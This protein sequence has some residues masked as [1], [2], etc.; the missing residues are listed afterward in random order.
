MANDKIKSPMKNN[1]IKQ[2][3]FFMASRNIQD[4]GESDSDKKNNGELQQRIKQDKMALKRK[5]SE[6]SDQVVR[7]LAKCKNLLE[8][9]VQTKAELK[10]I[11]KATEKLQNQSLNL[12]KQLAK[13]IET[14]HE[15]AQERE[16]K[17]VSDGVTSEQLKTALNDVDSHR[18]KSDSLAALVS[19]LLKSNDEIES[20]VEQAKIRADEAEVHCQQLDQCLDLQA[21]R[22]DEQR[23]QILSLSEAIDRSTK[24]VTEELSSIERIKADFD[25]QVDA[26]V[27]ERNARDKM[28]Q[29]LDRQNK[30]FINAIK[31]LEQKVKLNTAAIEESKLSV[32]SAQQEI[33]R[34]FESCKEQ[35]DQIEGW[36]DDIKAS[37]SQ[38]EKIL[39]QAETIRQATGTVVE[40]CETLNNELRDELSERS[41]H[42]KNK[43]NQL[44]S[45]VTDLMDNCS[46]Q[47]SKVETFSKL[48]DEQLHKGEEYVSRIEQARDESN[49]DIAGYI[50][51]F[52]ATQTLCD[53]MREQITAEIKAGESNRVEISK[54]KDE[55]AVSLNEIKEALLS[56]SVE[57]E[58]IN[59]LLVEL[60]Q[61]RDFVREEINRIKNEIKKRSKKTETIINSQAEKNNQLIEQFEELK[62][63]RTLSENQ[64][65]DVLHLLSEVEKLRADNK[66]AQNEINDC[67][68]Q[69]QGLL[70]AEE[71][72]QQQ[73][74]EQQKIVQ[75]M[76]AE[77]NEKLQL[78]N[79]VG[80]DS[81]RMQKLF[82]NSLNEWR[83]VSGKI[84]SIVDEGRKQNQLFRQDAEKI[85][86]EVIGHKDH[87]S[88]MNKTTKRAIKIIE[89]ARSQ[90]K[91]VSDESKRSLEK[92]D[93]I[94]KQAEAAIKECEQ[95]RADNQVV[96]ES[97]Q[98]FLE[99]TKHNS[100]NDSS[101]MVEHTKLLEQELTSINDQVQSLLSDCEKK[102]HRINGL[103]ISVKK[104]GVIGQ[105]CL[106]KADKL[107]KEV[108]KSKDIV[109][110]RD[111]KVESLLEDAMDISQRVD[112]ISKGYQ[113]IR[114]ELDEKFS[115]DEKI[116]H[117]IRS[118]RNE[119]H[120]LLE[121]GRKILAR[122]IKQEQ[123]IGRLLED[124][125]VYQNKAGELFDQCAQFNKVSSDVQLQQ[126]DKLKELMSLAEQLREQHAVSNALIQCQREKNEEVTQLITELTDKGVAVS[127]NEESVRLAMADLES[128]SKSNTKTQ[129]AL[130]ENIRFVK[131]LE[132]KL[133]DGIYLNSQQENR[134]KEFESD[135]RGKQ[136]QL[137]RALAE[138][139]DIMQQVAESAEH[140]K[141]EIHT[142]I[143]SQLDH[144][145]ENDRIRI[146]SESM[147][148][149]AS[150]VCKDVKRISQQTS[151]SIAITEQL[152]QRSDDTLKDCE[153]L[154]Q[155][156]EANKNDALFTLRE[157]LR[158]RAKSVA[159]KLQLENDREQNDQT[160]KSV[161]QLTARCNEALDRSE[162]QVNTAEEKYKLMAK[163]ERRINKLTKESVILQ[164][165]TQKLN[166]RTETINTKQL[167]R[168]DELM[169][170]AENYESQQQ[171]AERLLVQQAERN[172]NLESVVEEQKKHLKTSEAVI[173]KGEQF[174]KDAEV[175]NDASRRTQRIVVDQIQKIR[176]FY[177]KIEQ[178]SDD[179]GTKQNDLSQIASKM[180][181]RYDFVENLVAKGESVNE[182]A[183][184]VANECRSMQS[185]LEAQIEV[186][187][188][189][190]QKLLSKG[191]QVDQ[192][193][194]TYMGQ[195]KE[196][197]QAT[198]RFEQSCYEIKEDVSREAE[199]AMLLQ[200]K[201]VDWA[202]KIEERVNELFDKHEQ[203][204]DEQQEKNLKLEETLVNNE[205]MQ[206]QLSDKNAKY[207]LQLSSAR[208][209]LERWEDRWSETRHWQDSQQDL[210]QRTETQL[211]E[212][213]RY[214]DKLQGVV[215]EK[216]REG[217][218]MKK[219]LGVLEAQV[220]EYRKGLMDANEIMSQSKER[221]L[222]LSK[223]LSDSVALNK[224]LSSKLDSFESQSKRFAQAIKMAEQNAE[225]A[226]VANKDAQVANRELQVTFAEI[227][228][229]LKALQIKVDGMPQTPGKSYSESDA[230]SALN[231]SDSDPVLA[232]AQERIQVLEHQIELLT[233]PNQPVVARQRPVAV[234]ADDAFVGGENRRVTESVSTTPVTADNDE[235][236][237][238][239]SFL[240]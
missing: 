15:F 198:K 115:T 39:S 84:D 205:N 204:L 158:H 226:T 18:K 168:F 118:I 133:S 32:E 25:R 229:E 104:Q 6:A 38:C 148:K 110:E 154:R 235:K 101:R 91:S 41:V 125:Q 82:N 128:L 201:T 88:Q 191:D 199:S 8:E 141:N 106:L 5:N 97:T 76:L 74:K 190:Q 130:N 27:A 105:K 181:E 208:E 160:K 174:R 157:L 134:F 135:L 87:V 23:E 53:Q 176:A 64:V 113:S 42:L 136:D 179:I 218:Q 180:D 177:K 66:D 75:D 195:M 111:G 220:E 196:M 238:F 210:F 24:K 219:A 33:T 236:K 109:E 132:E 146:N 89:S 215:E 230:G 164:R 120:Q 28:G 197:S 99:E 237:T 34:L 173:L 153:S 73:T 107:L 169:H 83:A 187:R 217:E 221:E 228:N 202:K 10:E 114:S 71:S 240:F 121:Y 209:V 29:D 62:G 131:N 20:L 138:S 102:I 149:R 77:L 12:N 156:S 96:K 142:L 79:F 124:Q 145:A 54:V 100:E 68:D 21:G 234:H 172:E 206:R 98:A 80:T 65:Q 51:E 189:R 182:I 108:A 55:V 50:E 7:D 57:D 3:S 165:R 116:R 19:E 112:V 70:L 90:A 126:E 46:G 161:E 212:I 216:D 144:N 147:L 183:Q 119:T 78:L 56:E 175:L 92:M 129:K 37:T 61:E 122:G 59:R 203:Q 127:E 227:K 40:R 49:H 16:G 188:Q 213:N 170:L 2:K 162:S 93:E 143:R 47:L 31:K 159:L 48:V 194:T 52:K 137:D 239:K 11:A 222:E 186:L 45:N 223:Q 36:R 60:K 103:E 4:A 44:E 22:N 35:H 233:Q 81:Q 69:M 85:L 58:E 1:D 123:T 150:L 185:D 192:N 167:E 94:K 72:G 17:Q 225:S 30:L 139:K 184:S 193:I 26:V 67:V 211:R 140:Q 224:E 207:D 231:E 200:K 117:E 214:S 152:Q 155:E 13:G 232:K 86:Q 151:Q 14:I 171:Q 178:Q 95:I 9:A 63:K 43:M 163:M 166:S